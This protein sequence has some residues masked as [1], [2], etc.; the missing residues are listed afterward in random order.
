M[1]RAMAFSAPGPPE[2]MRLVEVAPR[3][4]G[5]GEVQVRVM[6]AGVQPADC[7]ARAGRS[8]LTPADG[9]VGNEFAGVVERVGAGVAAHAPG[10]P[11]IGFTTMGA[12]A[13]LVTVPA[14]QLAAK[15]AGMP[16]TEAAA[17]S[18]SGQTAHTALGELGVALG[19]TVLVHAAAGGVGSMAVQIARSRGAVV[20]G[21]ARRANHAYLR[22]LGAIPVE[23]GDGL[24]ARVRALAP[25]GVDAALDAV[26]GG[27]V[28]AS[29]ALVEDRSRIGTIVDFGAAARRGV[30]AIRTQRSAE[31][32]RELIAMWS[33]DELRVHVSRTYPLHRAPEA[34]REVEAGHVRGKV[35]LTMPALDGRRREVRPVEMAA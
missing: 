9:V 10:D 31:R 14:D 5:A 8:A 2:A 23:Y 17:L 27:A 13:E 20:I 34:H 33:W 29:L 12:Y 19:D 4:P 26:G 11:V 16:W 21:T 7:A 28:A 15:P 6:A 1:S 18:A 30:R 25:E 22:S 24:V 3:A 35:V 32:L